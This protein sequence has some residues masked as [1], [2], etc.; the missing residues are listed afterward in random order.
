MKEFIESITDAKFSIERQSPIF[1]LKYLLKIFYYRNWLFK[2][3]RINWE[4]EFNGNNFKYFHHPYNVT[5][6]TE[7]AIEIPIIKK[8]IDRYKNKQILELGNVI[9]HYYSIDH[10]I[11]DK[12]EIKPEIINKDILNYQTDKTYDLIFS[13]STLEHIGYDEEPRAPIKPL[14]TIRKLK[15]LKKSDGKIVITFPIGY[16]P[17]LDLLVKYKKIPFDKLFFLKRISKDNRWEQVNSLG[18]IIDLEFGEPFPNANGL[19]IGII[20]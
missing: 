3:H 1:L 2:K 15:S 10:D 8:Y 16:N 13:I 7:R 19:V 9:S 14:T 5:W 17:Y 6:E 4:F 18:D 11:I 20:D 12:Y